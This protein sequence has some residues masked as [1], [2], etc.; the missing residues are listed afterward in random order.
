M[1][2][3]KRE[4]CTRAMARHR[5]ELAYYEAGGEPP[6]RYPGEERHRDTVAARV[7]FTIDN[8]EAKGIR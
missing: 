2:E 6:E 7:L 1:T 5:A 4:R 8:L 3:R